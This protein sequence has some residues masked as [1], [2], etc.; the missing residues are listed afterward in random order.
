MNFKQLI[1]LIQSGL[2]D[3]QIADAIEFLGDTSTLMAELEHD[4]HAACIDIK[5]LQAEIDALKAAQTWQ[6]IETAPKDG[7]RILVFIDNG[8]D[9]IKTG[10]ERDTDKACWISSWSGEVLYPP[11]HWMPLPPAPETTK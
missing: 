8:D 4:H 9:P 6:P 7:T 10:G 2:D 5:K 11:T 1:E 3:V